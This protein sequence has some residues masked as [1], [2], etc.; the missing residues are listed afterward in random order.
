MQKMA[1]F[2]NIT[3]CILFTTQTNQIAD[4]SKPI[5]NIYQSALLLK[6]QVQKKNP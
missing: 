5:A 4:K 3:S 2:L 6:Y 1:A